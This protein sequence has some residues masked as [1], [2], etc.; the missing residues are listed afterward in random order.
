M[1]GAAD[2]CGIATRE[3]IICQRKAGGEDLC[4]R[5]SFPFKRCNGNGCNFLQQTGKARRSSHGM[6]WERQGLVDGSG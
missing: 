6:G 4:I 1:G 2:F 3:G 5:A